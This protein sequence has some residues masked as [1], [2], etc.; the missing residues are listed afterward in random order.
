MTAPTTF[1]VGTRYGVKGDLWAAGHHTGVDYLTPVGSPIDAPTDSVILHAGRGGWGAAYGIHVIGKTRLGNTEYRWIAAHLSRTTVKAAD[2]VR[3]GDLV[4]LSGATGNV[5]GPHCHFEVRVAPYSYGYDVDPAKLAAQPPRKITMRHRHVHAN[6][7]QYMPE[8]KIKADVAKVFSL[9]PDT[10]NFNE[11]IAATRVAIRKHAADR[12]G[13]FVG[14]GA[15]NQLVTVW[16]KSKYTKRATWS[17]ISTAGIKKISPARGNA[18]V[19]LEHHDPD[20]AVSVVNAHKISQGFTSKN[21]TTKLRAA[22]WHVQYLATVARVRYLAAR[23]D[24]VILSEDANRPLS[25]WP[26]GH[27]YRALTVSKWARGM[28]TARVVTT[29]ATFGKSTYDYVVVISKNHVV[30]VTNVDVVN[31]NSDHHAVAVDLAW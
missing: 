25:S 12:Y 31:L 28:K 14:K 4:G 17:R 7:N 11:A 23:R 15:L 24:V 9:G 6:I 19:G 27:P 5:T 8:P 10:G 26:E 18:S 21:R 29:P 22:R 2:T 13:V 3:V 20:Q 16:R 1:P 30:D